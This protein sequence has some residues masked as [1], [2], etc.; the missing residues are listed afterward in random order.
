[1]ED[2]APGLLEK[3]Q[4]NFRE[5]YE[6]DEEIKE[7]LEKLQGH[8]AKHPEAYTYAGKVGNIL[9]DAYSKNLSS[10]V[11]PEGKMWYNIGDRIIPTTLEEIYHHIS[12]YV[13]E[14][15]AQLNQMAGIG[16]KPIVP[17]E[18]KDRVKGII[19]RLSSENDF[20]KIAWILQEPI[21]TIARS[22]VDDSI[23]ANAEFH[24]KAGMQPKIIRK[25]SGKCCEWCK[26][27]E[28]TYFYPNVP[29]EVY[30]R[31]ENCNCTVEYDP[32]NGKRKNVHT[33]QERESS[34]D[35]KKRENQNS[36][37]SQS[38]FARKEK[39]ETDDSS[40]EEVFLDVTGERYKNAD[41]ST[42]KVTIAQ[43]YSVDGITYKV[44]G[45]YVVSDYSQKEKEI[46]ELI[47]N[48]L[49]GEVQI[50]PR[51]LYPEKISTPDYIFQGQRYD[52][53]EP[54]GSGKN[55]LYN[56][57]AKKKSQATNSIFDISKCPLE[58]SEIVKQV[59]GLYQSYH[60]RFIKEIILIENKDIVNIFARK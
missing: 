47:V 51:V 36:A 24:G 17:P 50:I 44:D 30:S 1:M 22:I 23:E 6:S 19:D 28:N 60:T 12:K 53:K 37:V 59:E 32:G 2:I 33:K 43:E 9:A 41:Y 11:L 55:V 7:L 34:T 46:A 49:G 21:K 27:L 20:D 39:L 18:N 26:R 13:S 54:I 10:S 15:Q 4:K 42:K 38:L 5:M 8:M 58:K 40:N 31:H 48:S 16:I 14:V 56:M 25:S 57:V 45:K 35:S 3:I 29:K 52:L